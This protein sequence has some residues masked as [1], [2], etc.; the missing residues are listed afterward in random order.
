MSSLTKDSWVVVISITK[1]NL[2]RYIIVYAELFEFVLALFIEIVD[3]HIFS[4][5]YRIL[6]VKERLIMRN[7]MTLTSQS[8]IDTFLNQYPVALLYF[9]SP[10]CSVCLGLLP[11][12]QDL[13]EQF[14]D[15]ACG[16]IDTHV[17]PT[18]ASKY[19]ILSVPA[20][21]VFV[22]EKEYL[23]EARFIPL[24]KLKNNLLRII[25]HIDVL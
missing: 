7:F 12:V 5:F 18:V 16:L 24:Q 14:P 2:Y 10:N 15:I 13:M 11:Q 21:L 6:N 23:R 8:E 3:F 1:L 4:H 19:S 25:D 22:K 17:V 9:S 20:I